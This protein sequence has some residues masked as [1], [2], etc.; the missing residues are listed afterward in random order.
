MHV[1]SFVFI[2]YVLLWFAR[3]LYIHFENAG[4]EFEQE[5]KRVQFHLSTGLVLMFT[6]GLLM[7]VNFVPDL[8]SFSYNTGHRITEISIVTADE[9]YYGWPFEFYRTRETHFIGSTPSNMLNAPLREEGSDGYVLFWNIA[10]WLFIL[11]R[12]WV[13]VAVV[14][15][16]S[17]AERRDGLRM[18]AY[19]RQQSSFQPA[20]HW[21]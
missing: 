20:L 13:G 12:T 5:K 1:S 21:T 10:A 14:L 2:F 16:D 19:A 11:R 6:I 7:Q 3:K 8:R 18:S 15:A 17:E 9:K 4:F